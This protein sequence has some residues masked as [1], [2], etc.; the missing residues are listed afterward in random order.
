MI[1]EIDHGEG[2]VTWYVHSY[3]NEIMVSAG[4]KVKAGEQI[5]LTGSSGY[6][7][8]CH[9]HFEVYQD[10]SPINPINFMEGQGIDMS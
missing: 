3:T 7:T 1:I 8:G 9:L 10:D 2:L 4:Q 6:S 5:A